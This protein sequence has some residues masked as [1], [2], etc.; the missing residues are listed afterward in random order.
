[1]RKLLLL[2]AAL[3]VT[4]CGE[5][6]SPKEL[7]DLGVKYSYGEGVSEDKKEAVKCYRKAAEQGLVEAQFNIGLMYH[8]GE[9]VPEHSVTAYAWW[10]IAATNG[11][12]RAKVAK[13]NLAKD[14]TPEQ[15]AK[16]QELSKEMVK[17]NPEL[18]N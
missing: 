16:G 4:G 5:K 14:M 8:K 10:N 12:E 6:L 9:G 11:K 18:L 13:L 2:F 3:L 17:K 15:I 1:M 7:N